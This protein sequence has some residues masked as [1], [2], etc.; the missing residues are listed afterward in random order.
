MEKFGG[1]GAGWGGGGVIADGQMDGRVAAEIPC[2][3]CGIAR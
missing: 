2:G 1:C 3:A